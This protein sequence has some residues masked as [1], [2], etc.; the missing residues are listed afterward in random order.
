MNQDQYIQVDNDPIL[1]GVFTAAR[2]QVLDNSLAFLDRIN[3]WVDDQ[4]IIGD[5]LKELATIAQHL[6]QLPLGLDRCKLWLTYQLKRHQ[7][8]R[9]IKADLKRVDALQTEAEQIGNKKWADILTRWY[10]ME[11]RRLNTL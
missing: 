1:E 3:V 9:H 11:R 10:E 5:E 4:K 2:S 6:Q 8:R 7:T